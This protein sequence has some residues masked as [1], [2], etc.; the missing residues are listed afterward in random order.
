MPRSRFLDAI[1]ALRLEALAQ[2]TQTRVEHL[3]HQD[4]VESTF[5]GRHRGIVGVG[6]RTSIGSSQGV[7]VPKAQ[8][9]AQPSDAWTPAPVLGIL[10]SQVGLRNLRGRE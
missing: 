4:L 10:P 2:V 6:A 5:G 7:G 3:G 9:F 8:G 1:V